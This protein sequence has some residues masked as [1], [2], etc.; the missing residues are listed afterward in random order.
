MEDFVRQ[1]NDVSDEVVNSPKIGKKI[2]NQLDRRVETHASAPTRA[3][4]GDTSDVRSKAGQSMDFLDS[5]KPAA[6]SQG[7]SSSTPS[8]GVTSAPGTGSG[9]SPT[10]GTR[11]NLAL[12][13][14]AEPAAR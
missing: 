1:P 11:T 14:T 6:V 5:V 2:E 9:G 10:E 8:S 12:A 3:S 7:D 4:Q 13:A